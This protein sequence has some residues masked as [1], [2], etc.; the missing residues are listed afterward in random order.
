[1]NSELSIFRPMRDVAGLDGAEALNAILPFVSKASDQHHAKQVARGRKKIGKRYLQR[2]FGTRDEQ[3]HI[4]ESWR[5]GYSRYDLA[6]APRRASPWKW[7]DERLLVDEDGVAR[8][9]AA[10][11]GSIIE[12]LKPRRVLDVGC[13]DGIYPFLLAGAFPEVSFAGIELTETGHKAALALQ[14]MPALPDHIVN[15]SLR[16]HVDRQA[17]KR[18]EFTYG[19]AC[20]M[21]YRTGEFDLVFTVAAIAQMEAVKDAALKEISRVTG[22][23]LLTFEMFGDANRN[24]WRRM[25]VASRGFFREPIDALRPYQLEPLWATVD[26]PQ[27]V[28]FGFALVL[29]RK[30]GSAE[31]M[32][33]AA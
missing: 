3:R 1:M 17:F 8:M 9:R 15:Y 11:I 30:A 16:E 22:G 19:D 21:P 12:R 28:F 2:L 24:L 27:D 4:E 26:F 20:A 33:F 13:G 18:I 6:G 32:P 29:S 31:K 23:H 14:E 25:S 7:R 10:I 5:N